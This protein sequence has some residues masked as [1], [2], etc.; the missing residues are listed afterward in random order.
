MSKVIIG[1]HGLG[2]KPPKNTLEKWWRLVIEEGLLNAGKP[3]PAFSFELV[4][5]ADILYKT[6][7]DENCTDPENHLFLKE[8]YVP[9]SGLFVPEDHSKRRKVL[10]FLTGQLETLFL[11][12]D[13]SLNYSFISDTILN[14]WFYYL[15]VYYKDKCNN[16]PLCHAKEITVDT[17]VT[18]GSPLGL[19]VV[20]SKIAAERR[21]NHLGICGI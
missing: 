16:D 13:F 4:Y 7:L 18:I 2:N 15:D 12:E 8:K 10:D 20:K 19:P 6:P 17:F 5:W 11:N 9:S 1:I 3:V 21:Q 14:H